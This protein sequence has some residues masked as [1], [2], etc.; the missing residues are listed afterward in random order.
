VLVEASWRPLEIGGLVAFIATSYHPCMLILLLPEK[1]SSPLIYEAE[2]AE[3][4]EDLSH[5]GKHGR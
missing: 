3:P 5:A 1:S 2:E 4:E